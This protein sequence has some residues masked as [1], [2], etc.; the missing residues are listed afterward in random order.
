MSIKNIKKLNVFDYWK[1]EDKYQIVIKL[2]SGFIGV[3]VLLSLLF[4]WGWRSAPDRLTLYLPP[5][6]SGG[7]FMK[8]NQILYCFNCIHLISKIYQI[9]V[10]FTGVLRHY[11]FN[12]VQQI[13]TVVSSKCYPVVTPNRRH[14]K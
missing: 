11:A 1:Q 10:D 8:A 5:D 14:Q 6:I 7:V 3:L 2:L 12:A 13:L 9:H 4:F